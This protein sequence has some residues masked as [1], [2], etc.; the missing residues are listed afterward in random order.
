MWRY[1]HWHSVWS[2]V[3]AILASLAV[4]GCGGG[5]SSYNVDSGNTTDWNGNKVIS[6]TLENTADMDISVE[7]WLNNRDFIDNMVIHE[8]SSVTVTIRN[9][10]SSDSVT[11]KAEYADG[12]TVSGTFDQDGRTVFT[13]SSNGRGSRM[14]AARNLNGSQY[15][16]RAA[17]SRITHRPAKL[18]GL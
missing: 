17:P 5:A 7:L 3:A 14:P 18:T 12:S 1:R 11:Y 2:I 15:V 8:N 4:T 16:N 13:Y 6:R 9:M 10:D